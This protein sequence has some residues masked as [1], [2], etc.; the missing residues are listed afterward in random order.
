MYPPPVHQR[1]GGGGGGYSGCVEGR[2]IGLHVSVYRL[3]VISQ[4]IVSFS[5]DDDVWFVTHSPTE[6]KGGG[7]S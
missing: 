3:E 5:N 1:Q 2:K 6:E 4:I 7:T